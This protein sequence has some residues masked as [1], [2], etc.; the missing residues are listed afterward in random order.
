MN[1]LRWFMPVWM[2]MCIFWIWEREKRHVTHYI[3]DILLRVRVPL[4]R[5]DIRLCMLAPDITATIHWILKKKSSKAF[6]RKTTAL[7]AASKTRNNLMKA[8]RLMPW[9]AFAT[10]PKIFLPNTKVRFHPMRYWNKPKKT[11][12]TELKLKRLLSKKMFTIRMITN[13]KI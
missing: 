8:P 2:G 9:S 11:A 10:T 13:Q 6:C 7:T 4:I 1:W 12:N 3:W 5:E